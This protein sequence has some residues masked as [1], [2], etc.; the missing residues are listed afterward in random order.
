MSTLTRMVPAF[1][2]VISGRTQAALSLADDLTHL[3]D[4]LTTRQVPWEQ[5]DQLVPDRFDQYWQLT[6][7]F[8]QIARQAWPDGDS[9][10][11]YRLTV[12]PTIPA[13]RSRTTCS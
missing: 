7:Q 1:T 13:Q 5:L 12:P 2:Y 6:L 8:L 11:P 9:S 10:R 3:M 4:D